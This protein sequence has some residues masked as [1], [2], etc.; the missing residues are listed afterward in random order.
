M[1]AQHL[2]NL[3]V[4]LFAI[5]ICSDAI[6][7]FSIMAPALMNAGNEYDA[8]HIREVHSSLVDD[9]FNKDFEVNT[10]TTSSK[11]EQ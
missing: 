9:L 1:P 7:G 5:C 11:F 4:S 3:L 2:G 8:D 6:L 10:I